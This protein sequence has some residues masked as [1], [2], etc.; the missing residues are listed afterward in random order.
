MQVAVS[1]RKAPDDRPNLGPRTPV[2]HGLDQPQSGC[3]SLGRAG[4]V[5][6][7]VAFEWVMVGVA[8]Q[9]L[10]LVAVEP[11]VVGSDLGRL[12]DRAEAREREGG[13]RSRG[14]DDREPIRATDHEVTDDLPDLRHVVHVLVVVEDEGR[15]DD[16][17]GPELRQERPH[18]RAPVPKVCRELAQESGRVRG[19]LRVDLAAGRDDVMDED[20]PVSIVLV[21]P[22]P[23]RADAG[24][25]APVGEERRL[26]V[27][28]I[29]DDE[30]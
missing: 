22:V 21:Q 1:T 29:G 20:G 24:P 9:A 16:R 18:D 8:E 12:A 28:R 19:E 23:E 6:E 14:D 27:A 7:Q 17:P 4:E 13:S 10:R 5:V 2:D 3:P 11:E 26:A 25:P 15:S 30:G